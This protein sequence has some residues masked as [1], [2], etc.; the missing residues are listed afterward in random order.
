MVALA[1]VDQT[2][3]SRLRECCGF[4]IASANLCRRRNG[5]GNRIPVARLQRPNTAFGIA[6]VT[7]RFESSL[8]GHFCF[9][10]GGG[11][12]AAPTGTERQ[13]GGMLPISAFQLRDWH[14]IGT[15]HFISHS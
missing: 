5:E 15:G 13:T 14:E 6:E 7:E 9:V 10:T 2:K 12:V 4:H 3:N 8:R 11:T 1:D